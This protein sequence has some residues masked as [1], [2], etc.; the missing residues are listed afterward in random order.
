MINTCLLGGLIREEHRTS[1]TRRRRG[2][3]ILTGKHCVYGL[4]DSVSNYGEFCGGYCCCCSCSC[5]GFYG[6]PG[7]VGHY[8]TL[9]SVAVFDNGGVDVTS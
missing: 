3:A 9:W 1:R 7:H 4:M 8:T 6:Q 2:S 5:F